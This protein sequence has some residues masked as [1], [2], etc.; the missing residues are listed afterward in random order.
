MC[1]FPSNKKFPYK[2]ILTPSMHLQIVKTVQVPQSVF[3]PSI[4]YFWFIAFTY[5]MGKNVE[6]QRHGTLISLTIQS[7]RV[8]IYILFESM[9]L[10][11]KTF[12]HH[13]ITQGFVIYRRGS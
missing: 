6:C 9:L 4:S 2:F 13:S 8:H 10:D 3:M 7:Y 11:N 5:S 12:L 1:L